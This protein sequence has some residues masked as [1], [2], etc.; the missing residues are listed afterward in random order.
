MTILNSLLSQILS[1]FGLKYEFLPSF[2]ILMS[3]WWKA[4]LMFIDPEFFTFMIIF[5]V[6]FR[7]ILR[8]IR[9][10]SKVLSSCHIFLS[11]NVMTKN[12]HM[13]NHRFT[14]FYDKYPYLKKNLEKNGIAK[15]KFRDPKTQILPVSNIFECKIIFV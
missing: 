13:K 2:H 3:F 8:V 15:V 1:F 11:K 6:F 10:V 4:I 7:V 14:W 12:Q 9:G 5:F